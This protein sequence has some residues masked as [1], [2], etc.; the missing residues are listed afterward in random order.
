[1]LRRQ[2]RQ[3][4]AALLA[5]RIARPAMMPQA[6]DLLAE[7][8]Q[9]LKAAIHRSET[10]VGDFIEVPQLLHDK[11]AERARVHLALAERAQLVTNA[12]Y[13]LVECLAADRALFQRLFHS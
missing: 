6:F 9:V 3:L 8:F 7:G 10:H 4:I 2:Q 1:G 12:A 5:R 13:G 11:L